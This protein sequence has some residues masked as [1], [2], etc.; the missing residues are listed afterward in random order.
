MRS[1]GRNVVS[2]RQF[3]VLYVRGHRLWLALTCVVC[4]LGCAIAAGTIVVPVPWLRQSSES[5]IVETLCATVYASVVIIW[6]R[7]PLSRYEEDSPLSWRR[8]DLGVLLVLWVGLWAAAA[9]GATL[10]FPYVASI[11]VGIV[12]LAGRWLRADSLG[13]LVVALLLVQTGL[14]TS[15]NH[16]VVAPLF[17]IMERPS[18][19]QAVVVSVVAF[20]VSVASI[21]AFKR[22][23]G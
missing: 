17:F 11:L 3:L 8:A 10:K 20:V 19:G 4:C 21:G 16:T 14:W 23:E 2:G 22:R 15:I 18:L 7:T 6:W 12:L 1:V 9:A 5:F 13:L